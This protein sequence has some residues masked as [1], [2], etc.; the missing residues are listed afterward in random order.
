MLAY[1]LVQ[2]ILC[3]QGYILGGIYYHE[4]EVSIKCEALKEAA[5]LDNLLCTG[6]ILGLCAILVRL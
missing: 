1:L 2:I 3:N 6:Y 4:H 5:T